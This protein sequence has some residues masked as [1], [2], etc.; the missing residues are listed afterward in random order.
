[1]YFL[2]FIHYGDVYSACSRLLLRRA[3]DHCTAKKNS[4]NARVEF[5][6]KNHGEQ[7]LHQRKSIP[8]GEPITANAQVCLVEL[9]SKR[10]QEDHPSHRAEET[11][12]YGAPGGT[13]KILQIGRRYGF[14]MDRLCN[15]N[16]IM[17]S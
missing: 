14:Y 13:A 6:R 10:D 15:T 7:S 11:A 17:S 12:T 1:M 16:V 5:V 9:Q 3:P 2:S 8:H 4:L